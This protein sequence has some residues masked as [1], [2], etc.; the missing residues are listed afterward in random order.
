MISSIPQELVRQISEIFCWEDITNHS[1]TDQMVQHIRTPA[2][3]A[4]AARSLLPGTRS[5]SCR[6]PDFT[7][8]QQKDAGVREYIWSFQKTIPRCAISTGSSNGKKFC[9]D[10]PPLSRP[11]TGRQ[12]PSGGGLRLPVH[13]NPGVSSQYCCAV[14]RK[15]SNNGTKI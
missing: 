14:W 6:R 11:E 15:R 4:R 5:A 12:L 8:Q 3:S 10:R 9:W 7:R 2:K 13:C 1:T